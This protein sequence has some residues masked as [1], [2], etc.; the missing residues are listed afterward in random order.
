[1]P[2][3]IPTKNIHNKL[4]KLFDKIFEC[5]INNTETNVSDLENKIDTLVYDLYNIPK[6]MKEIIEKI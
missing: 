1:M 6:A 3:K 5:R 2:I 4:E